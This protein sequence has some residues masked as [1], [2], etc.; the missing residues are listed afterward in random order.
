M[1]LIF[2]PNRLLQKPHNII[3]KDHSFRQKINMRNHP[4]QVSLN[5]EVDHL[6]IL[7]SK[8]LEIEN[9]IK[10]NL[11]IYVK[12]RIKYLKQ[13]LIYHMKKQNYLNLIYSKLW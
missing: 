3:V 11:K 10:I 9:T 1:I 5:Q 4:H 8:N 13:N 2:K 12:L 7:I 6:I